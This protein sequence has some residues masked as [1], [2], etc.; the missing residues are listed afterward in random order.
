VPTSTGQML[1]INPGRD[2]VHAW[3]GYMARAQ[4]V[5]TQTAPVVSAWFRKNGGT[6]EQWQQFN[7]FIVAFSATVTD[8]EV[9]TVG[10]AMRVAG[11]DRLSLNA[12]LSVGHALFNVMLGAYFAGCRECLSGRPDE[13]PDLSAKPVT[14][15]VPPDG[16]GVRGRLRRV[17]TAL[18]DRL[19]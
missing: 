9:K 11:Y 7:E 8:P 16:H 13:D 18:A 3:P 12:R 1:W 19:A 2:I 17:L 15:L 14:D 4:E 5:L 6:A 10:D